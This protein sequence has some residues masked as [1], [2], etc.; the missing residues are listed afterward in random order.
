MVG[1]GP[2]VGYVAAF[3]G[4]LLALLSPCGAL[5]LPSFFAYAFDRRGRLLA[6][7]GIFTLGLI[8]TLVPLGVSASVA[9]RFVRTQQDTV[10]TV[11]G[12]AVI[13]LGVL[14]LIGSGF[15]LLPERLRAGGSGP[16]TSGTVYLLGLVYGVTGFC[17][18]PILGSILVIAAVGG[19]PVQGGALLAVYALGMV[20]P[21]AL[22][23]LVWER[24]GA[25]TMRW[26]R[27]KQI[28]IG[29]WRVHST[30]LITGLLLIGV[31]ILLVTGSGSFEAGNLALVGARAEEVVQA[32]GR[33]IPDRVLA[34]AFV[35]AAAGWFV[36][37]WRADARAEAV[38]ETSE[39]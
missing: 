29:P 15:N 34:V 6:R 8:T 9:T 16:P 24:I 36:S 20:V 27:G 19:R 26:L 1:L 4:G 22:L 5:L 39:R 33:R 14:M 25:T 37:R 38:S 12:T 23:S 7:T 31:G 32:I 21:L 3:V 35:L 18:G 11:A 17:T 13:V 10:L 2:E 28:A 30:A